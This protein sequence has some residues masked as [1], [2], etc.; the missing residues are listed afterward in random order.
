MPL[1]EF[2]ALRHLK[3]LFEPIQDAVIQEADRIVASY[4]G[5]GNPHPNVVSDDIPPPPRAGLAPVRIANLAGGNSLL[6]VA[7]A[8]PQELQSL[9]SAT[10][11]TTAAAA[12]TPAPQTAG[13]L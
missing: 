13:K 2:L 9:P 1:E 6:Y 12:A 11:S 3:R 10:S 7:D 4:A 8:E 5:M